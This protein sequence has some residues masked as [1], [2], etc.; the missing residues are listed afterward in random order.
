ML[1]SETIAP[2]RAAPRPM[3]IDAAS[4]RAA[5]RRFSAACTI[6]TTA[7]NGDRA[8][9]TATAVCSLTA[10]PASLLVCINRSTYAH[11]LIERAGALS[12]N[13]LAR[14]HEQIARRF[15][16]MVPGAAP[17]TRFEEGHWM[18]GEIGMP[19]L[20]DA[21][22]IFECEVRETLLASTHSIFI[23]E[24]VAV[25]IPEGSDEPLIYFDGRFASLS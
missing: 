16:G 21:M 7:A 1:M 20:A 3:A 25:T 14:E 13:V 9:F 23:C 12:V 4:F 22:A 11:G 5:M 15:A 17:E 19:V 8:G 6:V 2:V 10:E 18:E 24:V